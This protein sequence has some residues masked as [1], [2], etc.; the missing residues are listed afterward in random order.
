MIDLGVT[1]GGLSDSQVPRDD[2][3][4]V[5]FDARVPAMEDPELR[6]DSRDGVGVTVPEHDLLV[7]RPIPVTPF[8]AEHPHG[9]KG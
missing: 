5:P 1:E 3:L 9:V 2:V 8:T 7:Q 4:G 6:A